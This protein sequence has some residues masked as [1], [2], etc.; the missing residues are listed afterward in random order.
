MRAREHHGR[1]VRTELTPVVN[2]PVMAKKAASLMYVG[3]T[4]NRSQST[5]VGEDDKICSRH[6]LAW[7]HSPFAAWARNGLVRI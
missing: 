1:D 2:G 6:P 4:F 7:P 5:V 3:A